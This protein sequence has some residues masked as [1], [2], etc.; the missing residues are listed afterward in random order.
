MDIDDFQKPLL[1]QIAHLRAAL[2]DK[3]IAANG[4]E[5]ADSIR[6]Q[7]RSLDRVKGMIDDLRQTILAA[8]TDTRVLSSPVPDQRPLRRTH[9]RGI[10]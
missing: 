6:G 5:G 10:A 1:A 4:D 7:I 8:A 3:L 9:L 2:I